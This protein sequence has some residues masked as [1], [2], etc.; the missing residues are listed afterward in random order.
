MAV[1]YQGTI[2][3][4]VEIR[5]ASGYYN[6]TVINGDN[7]V[8]NNVNM[9]NLTHTV[10]VNSDLTTTIKLKVH[11]YYDIYRIPTLT[12]INKETAYTFK[13]DEF[14]DDESNSK[15]YEIEVNYSPISESVYDKLRLAVKC[16][17][18][19]TYAYVNVSLSNCTCNYPKGE[20]IDTDTT[21]EITCNNDY[22]FQI[23][24]T[25]NYTV[26]NESYSREFSKIDDCTYRITEKLVKGRYYNIVGEASKKTIFT[27]KY[28]LIT[29]YRLTIEE[30]REI[31][32]SRWNKRE[33]NPVSVSGTTIY[34]VP[35]DEYI[36]TAKYVVSLIKLFIKLNTENKDKL[37][38]GPFDMDMECD[39][40]DN[41][42]VVLNCGSVYIKGV[43]GNSIDYEDTDIE[44]YLPYIGFTKLVTT[45]FMNKNVSLSYQV[46]V[47]NGESLAIISADNNVMATYSCNI[48]V[49]IPFQ[50]GSNE[51]INPELSPNNNYLY[52]ENPFIYVKAHCAVNPDETLPY[53]DTKFYAVL[54]TLSGYTEATEIDFEVISDFIT[55]TEIDEIKSLLSNGVFL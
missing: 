53:H 36:D 41:D 32:K 24:P 43:Y 37:Y 11:R 9:S 23:M 52:N 8:A 22:E 14:I 40:I 48:S 25:L 12:F 30:L 46:N 27:D 54:G 13:S 18:V 26:S 49:H 35:N 19:L 33:L 45:D 51:Y 3:N 42:L 29:A 39:T 20:Y 17:C 38:F 31:S 47:I 21:F 6:A 15:N 34:Y 5:L 10:Y 2:E 44:I 55:K 50:L 7:T 1:E 28:G 4:N 16:Q